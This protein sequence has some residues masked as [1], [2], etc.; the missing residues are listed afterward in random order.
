MLLTCLLIQFF[1]LFSGIWVIPYHDLLVVFF[2]NYSDT[3]QLSFA[4]SANKITFGTRCP[5]HRDCSVR[6]VNF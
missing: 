4:F 2:A 6:I 5:H 1:Y 3:E